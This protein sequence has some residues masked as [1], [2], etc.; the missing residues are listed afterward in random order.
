ADAASDVVVPDDGEEVV[1]IVVVER[2]FLA[3]ASEHRIGVG[4]DGDVVRV[5]VEVGV[6]ADGHAPPS[7]RRAR[8]CDGPSGRRV[9]VT[10][11]GERA[12]ATA[13]TTAGGAPMAPPSPTPL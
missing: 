9:I 1:L 4:V 8:I 11:N 7:S 13:F 2:R 12:S 5:V 10:P 6:A 3:Q